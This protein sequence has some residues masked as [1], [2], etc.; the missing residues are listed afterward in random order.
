MSPVVC[1]ARYH[2]AV[3]ARAWLRGRRGFQPSFSCALVESNFKNRASCTLWTGSIRQRAHALFLVPK[4]RNGNL[5][6]VNY[7]MDGETSVF[8]QLDIGGATQ[9]NFDCFR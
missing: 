1:A 6:Q 2:S 3:Q 8:N 4:D 9:N 5:G 7:V